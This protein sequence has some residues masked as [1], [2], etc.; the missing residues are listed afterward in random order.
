MSAEKTPSIAELTISVIVPVKNEAANIPPLIDE[1]EKALQ[2]LG[3][4]EIIY[5]NDGSSDMSGEVLTELGRTRPW[6]RQIQHAASAGQSAAVRSGVKAARSAI[7]ATLDGDGQNNPAYIPALYQQ[8]MAGGTSMGLAAGQRIGRR[9]SGFKRFQSRIAN[10]VRGAILKD[11]TRDSGCGLKLF[12]REAFLNLPYFDV[13]HRFLPALMIRE[14]YAICH[15]DVVDRPRLSGASNYGFWRRA[16]LGVVDLIGVWW[17]LR[18]RKPGPNAK[19]VL[20]H[21]D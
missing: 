6:L 20:N 16:I 14:G 9:D 19:E 18:R 5:V 4:F 7:I 1:L 12:R 3:P 2:P 17:L 8:L 10:K 21:A 11:G 15:V 13:I